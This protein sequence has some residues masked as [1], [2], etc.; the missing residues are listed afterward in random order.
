M[1]TKTEQKPEAKIEALAV[2]DDVS[3]MLTTQ[4]PKDNEDGGPPTHIG[5]DD[6]SLPRLAIAQKT[7]SQLDTV[8]GLKFGHM[9]HSADNRNWGN[10]PIVFSIL[11]ADRPRYMILR[12]MTDGGGIIEK[13][14]K[15]SDPRTQFTIDENGKTVKPIATKFYDFIVLVLNGFDVADPMNNVMA[16]SLKSTGIKAAKALNNLI[17]FRGKKELFRGAYKVTSDT[18]NKGKGPYGFYKFANAGWLTEGTPAFTAAHDMWEALKDQVI[19]ID[20]DVLPDEPDDT[21]FDTRA[22]EDP[23]Q[24]SEM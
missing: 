10:G 1:A 4:S 5:K 6:V 12:P 15:E 11:R 17:T 7:S 14:V 22:M 3:A 19:E 16:I 23:T 18:E 20:R 2:V 13:D 8:E 9:F 24:Q 21:S